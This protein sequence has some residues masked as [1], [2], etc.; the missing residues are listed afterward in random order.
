M[1]CGSSKSQISQVTLSYYFIV[2]PILDTRV[3]LREDY[4]CTVLERLEQELELSLRHSEIHNLSFL[5]FEM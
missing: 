3:I 5:G 4:D 2:P 1:M